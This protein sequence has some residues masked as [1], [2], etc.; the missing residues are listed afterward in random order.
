MTVPDLKAAVRLEADGDVAH[1]VLNRPHAL[2][3]LNV[4][5]LASLVAAIEDSREA[6]AV[7][8]YGEGRAFCVGEDLRETL[9]PQTGA[10][11]ELRGSFDKLQQLTRLLNALRAPVV[12]AAQGYAIGGGAELALAGDL[13]IAGADLQMRF[14]EVPIGHAVTGGITA[15]L[16][17]TIGLIRAKDLLLTG[18][19]IEAEEALRFGMVTE[20][21]DDAVSRAKE[22][23]RELGAMPRGSMGATK[24]GVEVASIPH[25]ELVLNAE[26]DA[27]MV[28]FADERAAEAYE[29]FQRD[30]EADR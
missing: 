13:V 21:A 20:I 26:V 9:A 30:A 29:P 8:I 15:R 5:M 1:I 14:P 11:D 23:G 24:V 2:N 4:D 28:C 10:S 3:A 25:Q 27:A 7:V 17:A 16:T 6:A 22:L 12:I 19:W 18:R